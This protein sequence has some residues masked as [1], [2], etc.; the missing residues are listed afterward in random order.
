[1]GPSPMALDGSD[2]YVGGAFGETGDGSLTNLGNIARYDTAAG[3]WHA[4]PNQ[5]FNNT[6]LAL[7]ISSSNLYAGGY[8]TET[9]DESLTNLGC[10]ARYDTTNST[11]YALSN[12]GL[13]GGP[14]PYQ[15]CLPRLGFTQ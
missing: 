11:W 7:V 3:T 8:F 2:L 4:L 15:V 12:Q 9:D 6:V 10:V 1:V 14:L 5:G 13:D